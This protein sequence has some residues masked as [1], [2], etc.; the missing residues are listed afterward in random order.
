[1][2]DE[3]SDREAISNRLEA[4]V[5]AFNTRNAAAAC[6]IYARDLVAV[7]PESLQAS[8]EDVCARL[9][10]LLANPKI[11]AQYAVS[12]HEIL[13]SGNWAVVRLIWKFKLETNGHPEN[14]EEAGMDVFQRQPDGRWSIIRFMS[15]PLEQKP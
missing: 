14:S 7:T 3:V 2:A 1:M 9:A 4:W 13:V 5:N 10:K 8:R 15:F 12:I 11:Q 6:D